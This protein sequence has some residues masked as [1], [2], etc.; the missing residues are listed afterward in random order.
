MKGVM[1]M[2]L[3]CM[4][5]GWA[6]A[7]AGYVLVPV[8]AQP[9]TVSIHRVTTLVFPAAVRSGVRVSRDVQ[10]EKVRGVENVLAIRAARGRFVATNLAVFGLDGRIY[11]FN[12]EYSDTAAAWEYRVE[13]TGDGGRGLILTGLPADED[14]LREDARMLKTKRGWMRASVNTKKMRLSVTGIYYADSLLWL[15]GKIRNRAVP[16]FVVQRVRLFLEDRKRVKR[17]ALQE[18][19]MDPVYIDEGGLVAGN[20]TEGFAVAYRGIAVPDGKRVVLEFAER[21]GGRT[22]RVRIPLKK[23]L[24]A[25]K[26]RITNG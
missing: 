10:V 14:K 4:I 7:Q 24:A 22:M 9:V 18:A 3:L 2:G 5:W 8:G 13:P 17:M 12:L 15:A 23:L 19:D 16:D 26:L 20:T 25:R 11:S 1:G 21:D 6:G